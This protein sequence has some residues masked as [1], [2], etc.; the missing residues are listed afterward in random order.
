MDVLVTGGDGFIG[1]HLCDELAERGHQVT[2]LSRDPDTSVFEAD[3]ET[4]MGDITAYDSIESAFEGQDAVVNLV[5]LSPLFQPSD[6]D[7]QHLTVHLVG[8]ENAVRAAEEHGVERF[9]QMSALGADPEG[10]TAYI[11]A[12]GRAEEV[13]ERSTL[14]GTIFRPSVIFG[15]GGEFISFTKKLTPPYLAP[16][17]RGGRTRFQPIWVGDIVSML[18]D[19]LEE[20]SH[21]G[22][23][24]DIGGPAVLTLADVAKLAHSAEGRSVSVIPVPMELT[25]LGMALAGP[26]PFVPFGPDQARSLEMDN[27]VEDNDIVAFGRT[28]SDLTTLG[29]YLGVA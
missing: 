22:E 4:V 26:V 11:R 24:Y 28:E 7:D 6:G 27:T 14:D 3:I 20:D 16:L 2:A 5:A 18:A 8:T 23:T 21:A 25:K 17:P 1:R 12:K 29:S 15:D 9:V 10:A 13:V 19:A